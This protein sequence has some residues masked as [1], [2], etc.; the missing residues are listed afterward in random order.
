MNKLLKFEA[1]NKKE[2]KIEAIYNSAVYPKKGDGHLP[3]LYYLIVWKGYLKKKN[4]WK[5]F[6]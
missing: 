6:W 3:G 1:D 4:T 5:L 2:Y